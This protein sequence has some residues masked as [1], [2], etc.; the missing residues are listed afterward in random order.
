MDVASND[1]A[2]DNA[3]QPDDVGEPNA[4]HAA[5]SLRLM[6]S[7]GANLWAILRTGYELLSH[8]SDA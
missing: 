7:A 3:A 4:A 5:V 8:P 6:W 2:S 1:G